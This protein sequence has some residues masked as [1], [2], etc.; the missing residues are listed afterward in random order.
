[1]THKKPRRKC[2]NCS[3][4]CNRPEKIYCNVY[5]QHE[6]QYNTYIKRWLSGDES[7]MTADGTCTNSVRRWL[8]ERSGSKCEYCEWG[9]LN[10]HTSTI[11]LHI[12][13]K[14]G[15]S[16]N[17]LPENL[18]LL[19]PNCHSL[20]EVPRNRDTIRK[21]YHRASVVRNHSSKEE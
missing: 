1:M 18:I 11:P 6:Y 17:N 16:D 9:V 14:D 20:E 13:H 21:K 5:C 19:C 7:G 2:L 4:E 15:N 10:K 12:H 3:Q 8:F